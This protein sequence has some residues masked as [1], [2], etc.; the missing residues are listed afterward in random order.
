MKANEF[1][2]GAGSD[3][4]PDSATELLGPHRS[5][6]ASIVAEEGLPRVLSVLRLSMTLIKVAPK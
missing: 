5:T 4:L 3:A 2:R 1:K 6:E